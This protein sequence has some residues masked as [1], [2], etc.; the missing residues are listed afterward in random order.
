MK[1]LKKIQNI[2]E[3]HERMG[4]FIFEWLKIQ[5]KIVMVIT[6]LYSY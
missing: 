4:V 5:Q 1:G 3:M 6:K 2:C